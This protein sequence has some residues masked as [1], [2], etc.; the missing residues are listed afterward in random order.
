MWSSVVIVK[1]ELL[2]T[3]TPRLVPSISQISGYLRTVFLNTSLKTRHN[4]IV[5][6]S[7]LTN[8]ALINNAAGFFEIMITQFI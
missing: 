4:Q 8:R 2:Y 1:Q 3:T 6:K 7:K 5:S